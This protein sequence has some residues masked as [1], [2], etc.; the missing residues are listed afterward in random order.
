MKSFFCRTW[1]LLENV[2]VVLHIYIKLEYKNP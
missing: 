2:S 1:L